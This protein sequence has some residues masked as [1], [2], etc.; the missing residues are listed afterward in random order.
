VDVAGR[1]GVDASLIS[2]LER[3]HLDSLS[4]RALRRIAATLAIRLEVSARWRGGELDRV[5]NARHGELHEQVA[6]LLLTAGWQLA[7]EVSFSIYGERGVIDILGWHATTSSLLV[8][9]LKTAIIDVQELVGTLDRK[10]RL[11]PRIAAERGWHP[12]TVSAWVIVAAG[13][14]NRRR[15]AAHRTM[16]RAAYP[17]D[18]R[19]MRGWLPRPDGPVMVL[20]MWSHVTPGH[21]RAGI[22][23]VQRVRTRS[24]RPA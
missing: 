15:I 2:R 19:G 14:T 18:G 12:R 4:L 21:V 24:N 5:V 1:S 13:I 11:A 9:E 20:S 23:P 7:P 8:I 17:T 6:R 10:V 3:G 22:A 16:L